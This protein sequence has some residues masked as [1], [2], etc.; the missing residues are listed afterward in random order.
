MFDF[1]NQI[2]EHKEFEN[3]S[4]TT[5]NLAMIIIES[6]DNHPNIIEVKKEAAE[7]ASH[8]GGSWHSD[9]SF[10]KNHHLQPYCSKIIPP[11]GGDTLFANTMLAYEGLSEH[12][13]KRSIV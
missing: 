9:W 7:K 8:F 3:F 4:L 1:P 6:I 11:V 12:L 5:E 13:K 2:L 10:Q